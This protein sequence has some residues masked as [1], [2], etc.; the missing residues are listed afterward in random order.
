[1][2][3]HPGVD[4]SG[5]PARDVRPARAKTGCKFLLRPPLGEPPPRKRLFLTSVVAIRNLLPVFGNGLPDIVV[6][7]LTLDERLATEEPYRQR[8]S[9]RHGFENHNL[10]T[11]RFGD[12]RQAA[13]DSLGQGRG[14]QGLS[15]GSHSPG[16]G[17]QSPSTH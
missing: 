10:P 8:R 3:A 6:T 2:R 7:F 14:R 17:D 9:Y 4:A 16:G 11:A 5:L 1:K 12:R 15:P 13:P